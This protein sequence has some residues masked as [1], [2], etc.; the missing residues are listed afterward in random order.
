MLRSFGI[1]FAALL[2]STLV[3]GQDETEKFTALAAA[4][5][6]NRFQLNPTTA[7]SAGRHEFDGVIGDLS[8][9]AFKAKADYYR[10]VRGQLNA[11]D[12]AALSVEHRFERELLIF[13]IDRALY[14]IEEERRPFKNIAYYRGILSPDTYVDREYAPLAVRQRALTK[15]AQNVPK[16]LLQVRANLEVPMPRPFVELAVG[17]FRGMARFLTNDVPPLFAGAGEVSEQEALQSGLSRAAAAFTDAGAWA[18]GLRASATD[19]YALSPDG[20]SNMLLKTELIDLPLAEVKRLGEEDLAANLARVRAACAQ[21]APGDALYDCVQKANSQK[22]EGGPVAR[23]QQ[24]LGELKAFLVEKDLVSIP[25]DD[26]ALV[27]QAPPHRRSNLAYIRR[28]GPFDPPGLPSIYY[29]A[30]PDP[31]WT[32]E[33]QVAYIPGEAQLLF[34]SVHEVWPGHFLQGLHTREH[35]RHSFKL[36]RSYANSE[37]FSHYAEQLMW[38]AGL[39]SDPVSEIGL[40]MGLLTRNVRYMS[41]VGLH[42]EGM[43]VAESE[44]L[45][46]SAALTSDGR[47]KRQAARGTYDPEYLKYTLGKILILKMRDRWVAEHGADSL[48]A[49]HDRFLSYGTAPL[50]LIEKYM[51]E[52]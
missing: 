20:F 33:Q 19:D 13:A 48:K 29:I 15:W 17:Y 40:L 22:P 49:F 9:E 43:S 6:E 27:A 18:E 4:Y 1:F 23:G 45:F 2:F 8:R 35:P 10:E 50:P 3:H 44:A 41:A 16:A 30:P 31:S 52:D 38:E 7:V 14:Y 37:G 28:P 26:Q 51:F 25:S 12:E 24:Q 5:L 39:R 34:I 47:A 42:T 11:L 32:A 46:I 36:L 21:I